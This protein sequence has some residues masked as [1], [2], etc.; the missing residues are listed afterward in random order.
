[1]YFPTLA[2]KN[3]MV[4]VWGER[5]VDGGGKHA[6][7]TTVVLA[8]KSCPTLPIPFKHVQTTY[9]SEEYHW[10]RLVYGKQHMKT[11]FTRHQLDSPDILLAGSIPCLS[12]VCALWNIR[13]PEGAAAGW[14][15]GSQN[16]SHCRWDPPLSSINFPFECHL[17]GFPILMFDYRRYLRYLQISFLLVSVGL[18]WDSPKL[19]T[20]GCGFI[21]WDWSE[22]IRPAPSHKYDVSGHV[23]V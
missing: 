23:H 20:T 18:S 1:M 6:R 17:Q 12:H 4:G 21:W 19:T 16:R 2:A 7:G 14:R 9:L 15:A 3:S 22:N 11:T 10:L 8:V 13:H 5:V